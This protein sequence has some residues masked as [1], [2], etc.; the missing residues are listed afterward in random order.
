MAGDAPVVAEVTGT[1]PVSPGRGRLNLHSGG[2]RAYP[3]TRMG[4]E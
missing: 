3:R 1:V 2:P 4:G